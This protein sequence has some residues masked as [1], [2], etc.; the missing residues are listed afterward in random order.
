MSS[1]RGDLSGTTYR[2]REFLYEVRQ[3]SLKEMVGAP[4][5]RGKWVH[6]VNLLFFRPAP[7]FPTFEFRVRSLI[8]YVPR[9]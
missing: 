6:A 9:H 1:S 4:P 8:D 5:M 3:T 7:S 2:W